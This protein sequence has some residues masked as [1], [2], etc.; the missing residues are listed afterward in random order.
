M[1]KITMMMTRSA[2]AAVALL[3]SGSLVA[4][5]K[6]DRNG[7]AASAATLT[8]A[9]VNEQARR[10]QNVRQLVIDWGDHAKDSNGDGD[11]PT[12][13]NFDPA[14]WGIDM[15]SMNGTDE[16]D[17]HI[18]DF[19]C[20]ALEF[21]LDMSKD[22]EVLGDCTCNG[23][24]RDGIAISCD[25]PSQCID[26]ADTFE[27]CG[28]VVLNFAF[29]ELG[30]VNVGVGVDIEGDD[31]EQIY[32]EY[33]IRAFDTSQQT[34]LAKYGGV[35]CDVCTIDDDF[36]FT[37]DCS[38]QLEGAT[39]ETCQKL[40]MTGSD[41]S[42]FIPR[43]QFFDGLIPNPLPP[44]SD[45]L[46]P[47]FS[48]G[49]ID[50]R[51]KTWGDVFDFPEGTIDTCSIVKSMVQLTEAFGIDGDC[52]CDGNFQDGIVMTCNFDTQCTDESNTDEGSICASSQFAFSVNSLDTIEVSVGVDFA[53]DDIEK[54]TFT[55]NLP[56]G[57]DVP[58]PTCTATLGEDSCECNI[59]D[60]CW[61]VDCPIEGGKVDTC[62]LLSF[63]LEDGPTSF[64]PQFQRFQPGFEINWGNF[65]NFTNFD[66]E[67]F[68]VTQWI[69][70]N[71]NEA[72]LAATWEEFVTGLN[73]PEFSICPL[74]QRA[75][76]MGKEFGDGGNCKCSGSWLDDMLLSCVFEDECYD[77]DTCGNVAIDI[78]FDRVEFVEAKVCVDPSTAAAEQSR[79]GQNQV[80]GQICYEYS[81]GI[82]DRDARSCTA[83]YEGN[84][85]A[86]CE[87][88]ES[89]C[90]TVDCSDVQ[91]G[92][93]MD[94]CQSLELGTADNAKMFVPKMSIVVDT[95]D[96]VGDKYEVTSA[97][98]ADANKENGN[99]PTNE[100][101]GNGNGNPPTN[102]VAEGN[103][104]KS[105]ASVALSSI[106]FFGAMAFFAT[107]AFV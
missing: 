24:L 50:W 72:E 33:S 85:C 48:W 37:L 54:F 53:E 83:E 45:I 1:M 15:S 77:L 27:I 59:D 89:Y 8:M 47:N 87:I 25:F 39:M 57:D 64:Y 52:K 43:M 5:A 98:T 93:I 68:N 78:P 92:A 73:L 9:S 58:E 14:D 95:T 22:F 16:N 74:L 30:S 28:E 18:S 36:C 62:Q 70:E 66:W 20:P 4:G 97:P 106:L 104:D 49:D 31:Y 55:Y 100:G 88:D 26:I 102:D 42:T 84:A 86:S 71:W 80:K 19:L 7:E 35:E 2:I 101:S 38:E 34:C 79:T 11:E 41:A 13:N 46:D 23:N 10:L 94:T 56:L 17:G 105:A 103:K 81:I 60:W 75:V 96:G 51:N 32:F 90:I 61:S 107:I 63:G 21:A 40:S 29:E 82:I 76:D 91:E 44:I 12:S 67:G 3:A 69:N 6:H 65:F 99:N